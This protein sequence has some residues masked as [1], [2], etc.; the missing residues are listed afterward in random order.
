[1][2][3]DPSTKVPP[4]FTKKII[5]STSKLGNFQRYSATGSIINSQDGPLSQNY[6]DF[7]RQKNMFKINGVSC[8]QNLTPKNLM[9]SRLSYIKYKKYE[10]NKKS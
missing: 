1:M 5:I 3:S 9:L 2:Q 7:S 4:F 6:T 10:S 8:Y